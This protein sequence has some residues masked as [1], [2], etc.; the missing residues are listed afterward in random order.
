MLFSATW[1]YPYAV[2]DVNSSHNIATCCLRTMSRWLWVIC[3]VLPSACISQ[4]V[5]AG[6]S[7]HPRQL[8]IAVAPDV[9][10]EVLEWGG[11][12][13]NLL[14]LAGGGNTAHIYGTRPR[15]LQNSFTSLE[16]PGVGRVSPQRLPEDISQ[17]S[18]VMML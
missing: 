8:F 9:R 1:A 12:G 16:S 3:L 7:T 13:R 17:N 10:L 14:L 5:A 18:L 11:S 6:T 4:Q 15:S 2:T